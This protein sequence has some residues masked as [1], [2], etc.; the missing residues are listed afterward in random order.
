MDIFVGNVPFSSTEDQIRE[1]FERFGE[2]VSIKMIKDFETGRSKGFGFVKMQNDEEARLAME[3][4]NGLLFNGKNLAV[5]EARP[6]E[7]RPAGGGGYRDGGNRGGGGYRDGGNRGG[8][9]YQGGG[10]R[11]G[12][13]SGGGGGYRDGGQGGNTGG[14]G[15]RDNGGTSGGG[16][17]DGG[18]RGGGGYRDGG[19]NSGGGFRER[20]GGNSGGYKKSGGH[21]QEDDDSDWK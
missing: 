11:G 6:Q 14:G 20:G 8:G 15:Y 18:N 4:L 19:G 13:Y 5:N 12:G 3:G 17:R 21:F 16:N 9:G 7:K 1:L 10:N 2:V